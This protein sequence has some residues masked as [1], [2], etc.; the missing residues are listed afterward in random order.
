LWPASN[1]LHILVIYQVPHLLIPFINVFA[2]A[3]IGVTAAAGNLDRRVEQRWWITGLVGLT[4]LGTAMYRRPNDLL[5]APLLILA[6]LWLAWL[7]AQQIRDD[8]S[9]R[10]RVACVVLIA[11][12]LFLRFGLVHAGVPPRGGSAD[13][14]GTRWLREHFPPGTQV[15]SYAP[16]AVW[17]ASMTPVTLESSEMTTSDAFW[18]WVARE[19]V[20]AVYVDDRLRTLEPAAWQTIRSQIGH[21]LEV[22]FDYA[23]KRPTIDWRNAM[24]HMSRS[25]DSEP[26][27]VL[28]RAPKAR[29][30]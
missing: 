10:M 11:G 27:Q 6:A 29:A 25:T 14:Q 15:G 28:V 12:A 17:A 24:F 19:K 16:G 13:E 2:L 22:A 3:G 23:S 5:L 20:E 9:T 18:A 26:I 21:G 30:Q 4:V 1:L 8:V 7:V